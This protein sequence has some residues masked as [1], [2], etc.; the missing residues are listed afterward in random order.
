MQQEAITR[1]KLQAEIAMRID[2]DFEAQVQFEKS[3]YG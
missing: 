3:F 2:D 1:D